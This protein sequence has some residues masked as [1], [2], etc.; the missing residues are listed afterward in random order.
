MS[1]KTIKKFAVL[2]GSVYII[3]ALA[4]VYPNNIIGHNALFATDLLHNFIHLLTGFVLVGVAFWNHFLLPRVIRT[5]GVIL[6]VLA[7]LGAWFTGGDIG[8]I[9]G[10]LTANGLGHVVH[11]VTG[12]VCVV[13]GTEV[14]RSGDKEEVLEH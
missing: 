13:V 3:L 4:T 14:F 12:I 9:L 6:V 5:V 11:L 2:L 1:Y 10:L 8:K 7:I